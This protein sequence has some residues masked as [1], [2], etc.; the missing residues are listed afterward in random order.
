MNPKKKMRIQIQKRA[1]N[2]E[3]CCWKRKPKWTPSCE[4]GAKRVVNQ[5]GPNRDGNNTPVRPRR[6]G[7]VR[8]PGSAEGRGRAGPGLRAR[9]WGWTGTAPRDGAPAVF[10]RAKSTHG[11]DAEIS[12]PSTYLGPGRQRGSVRTLC[13]TG[14]T[15][16]HSNDT[17]HKGSPH[18]VTP[19][20]T[21]KNG[22]R[23]EGPFFRG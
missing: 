21:A 16:I 17:A 11:H 13:G 15:N 4:G 12:L 1:K 23:L 18:D 14:D 19:A 10:I 6:N 3:G 5:S 7:K 8:T 22:A 9:P 2:A 20:E